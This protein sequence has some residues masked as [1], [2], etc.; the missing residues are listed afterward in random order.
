MNKKW[1]T[2][3]IG[4]VAV[5][6]VGLLAPRTAAKEKRSLIGAVPDDVFVCVAGRHNPERQFLCDYWDEVIS[7]LKES[8]IG[9]DVMELI[10]SQ[11]GEEQRAEVDR[12][13]E[14]AKKLLDGVDWDKLGGGEMVFAERMLKPVRMG[15]NVTMMPDMVWLLRGTEGSASK[16]YEGLVAILQTL[17]AEVNKA[18]GEEVLTVDTTPRPGAKV[19]AV[20]LLAKVPNTPPFNLAV[21]LHD[22]VIV[23]AAGDKILDE[24]LGLLEGKSS[25]KSL[26]ASKRFK[27]AFA[28]LPTAEDEMTFFDVPAFLGSFRAL[29]D[30]AVAG[31][32]SSESKDAVTNAYFCDEA[33]KLAEKGVEAYRQKNYEKALEYTKKA[34]EVASTDSR[35]MYNLA[36]VHA[37]LGN[38]ND[39]LTWLGK[40]VD[41][42]FHAPEQISNNSDLKSVRDDPR[43]EAALA[44]AAKQVAAKSHSEADQWKKV[45]TRLFD[46]PGMVDYIAA[47]KYTEGYTVHAEEIT[48]LVPGAADNPF[49]RVF[50]KRKPLTDFDRYLPKETVSFS[51]SGG[52]DLGELYR[53]LEDTLRGLGPKGEEL[54]AKWASMQKEL[55]LDVRK[56]ILGWIQGDIIQLALKQPAGAAKVFMIKVAD[57]AAAREKLDSAVAFLSTNLQQA[58]Q[59]NPG[60]AMLTPRTSPVTHEKLSGFHNVAIGMMQQPAVCGVSDGYLILGSSADAVALCLATAAGDHPNIRKN[61]QFMAEGVIPKGAIRSIS[62]TDKRNFGAEIAQFIGT[63]SML[64]GIGA[65]TIPNPQLQ[66]LITKVLGP[67]GKLGSI[68]QKI[69]FYKSSAKY[70]TFDG[71]MW[72]TRGVTNYRSPAERIAGR[73]TQP[74]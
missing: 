4:L 38:K 56:D 20:N 7:A 26:A 6:S 49:Y 54:L 16:N 3:T 21:A 59:T 8:G 10:V 27:Q 50:G 22:D 45:A 71:K 70:T 2:W 66:Q 15:K 72:Y 34:H 23:I 60:M 68:V 1:T 12:F 41:G 32:A 40:A 44:K 55:G 28:K 30:L 65:M 25:K 57:E 18:A 51:V 47:V 63:L 58:A 43:Y 64:G 74:E 36:C 73:T 62:F 24:V 35:I 37:M 29:G 13:K 39:A 17:I 33:N 9:S 67:L 19:A 69:D 48:A 61:S 5:L 46:V 14:L 42:G 11:L 52:I 53:F 31:A